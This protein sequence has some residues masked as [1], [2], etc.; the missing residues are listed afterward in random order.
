MFYKIEQ[1]HF[2][3]I[4]APHDSL[5]VSL[6]RDQSLLDTKWKKHEWNTKILNL[7]VR[8]SYMIKAIILVRR[9]RKSRLFWVQMTLALL[10]AILRSKKVSISKAHPLQS[11]SLIPRQIRHGNLWQ[12]CHW[13]CWYRWCTFT[14]EY[15]QVVEKIWNDPTV[16]FRGLGETWKNLKLNL[17][18]LSL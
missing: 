17:V 15:H 3:D 4:S 8:T 9:W 11:V 13:C 2:S 16:I 14:C 6:A 10:V 1:T 12:I 5:L 7:R 18:T